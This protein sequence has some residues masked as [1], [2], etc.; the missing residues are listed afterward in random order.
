M[1]FFRNAFLAIFPNKKFGLEF[2]EIA[3]PQKFPQLSRGNLAI[4]EKKLIPTA[5]S[6]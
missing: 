5:N 2:P 3:N 4:F 6:T 1:S